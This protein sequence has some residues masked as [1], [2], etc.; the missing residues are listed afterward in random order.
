[1][2]TRRDTWGSCGV[3]ATYP[4]ASLART[5]TR[6]GGDEHAYRAL[7]CRGTE[8]LRYPYSEVLEYLV[9]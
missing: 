7:T 3:G 8:V 2:A 6:Q 9:A 1:M 5:V 4:R